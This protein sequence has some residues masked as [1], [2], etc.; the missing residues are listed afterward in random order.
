MIDIEISTTNKCIVPYFHRPLQQLWVVY[1]LHWIEYSGHWEYIH[2]KVTKNTGKLGEEAGFKITQR[3][4][5]S[6]TNCSGYPQWVS[7][8]PEMLPIPWACGLDYTCTILWESMSSSFSISLQTLSYE[9]AETALLIST[10]PRA[11]VNWSWR[12]VSQ[13]GKK[14]NHY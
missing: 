14:K 12:H 4:L 6:Y 11:E 5:P 13:F 10:F 8:A 7:V 9:W 2:E 1:N 3:N